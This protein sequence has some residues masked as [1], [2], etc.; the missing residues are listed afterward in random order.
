MN[1][2]QGRVRRDTTRP[3]VYPFDAAPAAG[4]VTEVVPGVYWLQT[5]L[6]FQGLRAINLYL[7]E[8]GDGWTI[9]DCGY[10]REEVR[11]QWREIWDTVLDRRPVSRL[12]VTHFHP[13]HMGNSG[14]ISA[15]WGVVPWMTQAEWLSANLAARGASA[16]NV[17]ARL[18]F[19]RRYGLDRDG[20]RLFD[21]GVVRYG[22][23][24]TVP[25][26]YRR[27]RDGEEIVIGGR[28]WRVIVGEG[29]SPEH[30]S[31]YCAEAGVLISG[32]QVLPKITTNV[33]TSHMEPE[34]NALGLFL[35]SIEKFERL[36]PEDTLVLPSHRLPFTGVLTRLAELR[37]HH[38][39]RLDKLYDLT[40]DGPVTAASV[41]PGLFRPG[42]DGHQIGFA[43]GEAIAHL[44]YLV[45]KHRLTEFTGD[46]DVI[47]YRRAG[48][49]SGAAEGAV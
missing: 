6:P 35:R 5:P 49:E 11:E 45:S 9:V 10:G 30:A 38:A 1:D 36:L 32:D 12:I 47:R 33:S 19:F 18:R 27:I 48:G 13:D 8:D 29:H 37:D 31:L 44:K 2:A 17:E 24:V 20:R 43:M 3:I 41:I 16:D 22:E 46:D 40:A 28:G 14:W 39:S 23:G 26:H 34:G 4:T 25:E 7:L 42:L 15:E 21:E